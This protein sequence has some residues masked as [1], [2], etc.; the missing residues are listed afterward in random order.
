MTESGLIVV[1]QL[2]VIEDQL[3]KVQEQI[4]TRVQAALALP[5]TEE[6]RTAVKKER[7]ALKKEFDMLED[8]RKAVKRAILEPYERFE[9]V[10]KQCTADIYRQADAELKARVDA[11]E[12][13]LR[14]EKEEALRAWFSEYREFLGLDASFCFTRS[15]IR[16]TLSESRK[17]LQ[18][19][20]KAFLDRV[21][22]DLRMI[23]T[24]EDRD[25]VLAEYRTS[26]DVSAAV[27]AVNLRR[28][29]AEE[30]RAAREAREANRTAMDAA[31]KEVEQAYLQPPVLATPPEKDPN[32]VFDSC[33][34]TVLNVTREQLK[35]LKEF[36][37]MEGIQ[38]E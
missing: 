6:T 30:E 11:V 10:Y 33:T 38:Y 2:P 15:G 4:Q 14:Q 12:Y 29:A 27:T 25:E 21:A 24:L 23:E 16:V 3:R 1:K 7:A 5:C 32:E 20:A 18:E 13:G 36:L 37:N 26:L 31:A 17:S 19:R 28:K 34:F 35:R 9:A 8:R 22:G